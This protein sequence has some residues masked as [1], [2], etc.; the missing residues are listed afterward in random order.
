MLV[1]HGANR[2]NTFYTYGT[3]NKVENVFRMASKSVWEPAN[4]LE[5]QAT[6]TKII[7]YY[8]HFTNILK[9]N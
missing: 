3:K 5:Y 6:G 2:A 8:K 4:I 9:L 7:G 1:T